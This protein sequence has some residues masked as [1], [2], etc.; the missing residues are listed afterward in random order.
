MIHTVGKK[1]VW[2]VEPRGI[3][4]GIFCG[5][6][7]FVFTLYVMFYEPF[8]N[9]VFELNHYNI[10]II[11]QYN[12]QCFVDR[13]GFTT[14]IVQTLQLI[15][16]QTGDTFYGNTC[17]VYGIEDSYC[18]EENNAI[19]ER[20]PKMSNTMQWFC[21]NCLSTNCTDMPNPLNRSSIYI[22]KSTTHKI[23]IN[24]TDQ[25]V[26]AMDVIFYPKPYYDKYSW[27]TCLITPLLMVFCVCLKFGLDDLL[28][29]NTNE[30]IDM[31]RIDIR[32]FRKIQHMKLLETIILGLCKI[33][34]YVFI[35]RHI[36]FTPYTDEN[37]MIIQAML[38][39]LILECGYDVSIFMIAIGFYHIDDQFGRGY[40]DSKKWQHAYYPLIGM[41]SR[42]FLDDLNTAK[43]FIFHD[44]TAPTYLVFQIPQ[45]ALLSYYYYNKNVVHDG[46]DLAYL[47]LIIINMAMFS[48]NYIVEFFHNFELVRRNSLIRDEA[49]NNGLPESTLTV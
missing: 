43:L 3:F 17:G 46:L 31:S 32:Y 15:D 16:V 49:N 47:L 29:N 26:E 34:E 44:I 30:L 11:D 24:Q 35:I 2:F 18:A 33:F 5:Y 27:F 25:Y 20:N 19:I 8:I 13:L 4:F 38:Y 14:G 48:R 28:K 37:A 40:V 6:T 39:F 42:L 21:F 23:K 36:I 9:T 10:S 41:F 1:R 7:A 22:S 12:V 45:L